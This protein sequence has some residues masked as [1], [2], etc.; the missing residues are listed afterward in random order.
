MRILVVDDS[1]AVT[2]FM[3][4]ILRGLPDVEV[5]TAGDGVEALKQLA[6]GEFDVMLLDLN[7]P[8]MDGMKVLSSLREKS[9][10]SKGPIVIVVTSDASEKTRAQAMELGAFRVLHKPV[11][12][13]AIR[14][15]VRDAVGLP[16]VGA[17]I[18]DRRQSPRLEIPVT[19][20][21]DGW[22]ALEVVSHDINPYGAFLVSNEVRPVG[23]KA[24]AIM[25]LS[26]LAEPLEVQCEV[27]HVRRED[28][29]K[30]PRGFG[31][32]FA[33]ASAAELAVWLAAFCSPSE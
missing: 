27:M 17:A 30:L 16:G 31:V 6:Q 33:H 10:G 28:G 21:V 7:L 29:G 12:A 20:R 32:R 23:S 22:P 26:H 4:F 14:R 24:R 9:S 8:L 13:Y 1:S 11:Q 19:V 3:Q 25:E 5:V 2:A 18:E 15:A